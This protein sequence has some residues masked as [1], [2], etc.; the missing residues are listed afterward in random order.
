MVSQAGAIPAD[1]RQLIIRKEMIDNITIN[2][3][4]SLTKRDLIAFG[5]GESIDAIMGAL[6][7]KINDSF[8]SLIMADLKESENNFKFVLMIDR[9]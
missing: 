7:E 5:V 1:C 4:V 6:K 9:I 3:T 8:V 2:T